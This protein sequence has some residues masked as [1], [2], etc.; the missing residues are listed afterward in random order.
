MRTALVASLAVLGVA[1][2]TA[3]P[4][5]PP[6]RADPSLFTVPPEQRARLQIVTVDRKPVVRT[7]S[8]PAA[9]AFDDLKTSTVMPLVSG[10]VEKV[11]VHEGD[12]VRPGQPLLV[13]ASPDSSD[14]AANLTRDRAVLQ[15]K[16]VVLAR[17]EDLY[18]HQAISQ[19]ELQGAQL[20]V[21]EAKAQLADD[22]ARARITGTGMSHAELRSPIGGLVVSRQVSAGNAVSAGSTPCFVITDPTVV[23]VVA[24]LYQQDLAR[25]RVGDAA[26]I[27]SPELQAP[28]QGHVTY[29]GAAIDPDTLTVPVR[30]AVSNP[31]G[32]LKSGMY[33]SAEIQP[34]APEDA[35]VVPASAVLRDD[36][37]LPFVF[38]QASPGQFARRHVTLGD[39]VDGGDVIASGLRP[40]EQV[41]AGG[42]VFVQ[43]AESLAQ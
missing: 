33:V 16:K 24:Q 36:D 34:D 37:N 31:G 38:V 14:A 1:A 10:K 5:P 3:A 39:A 2:C 43:F 18:A 28:L 26:R 40:G 9:V 30:I 6:V 35:L 21:T 13:I 25:V 42:A 4:P 17:D 7:V 41:L 29:I 19:E 12:R 11:L 23:W 32:L 8:V 20:D 15:N 22:E 27:R